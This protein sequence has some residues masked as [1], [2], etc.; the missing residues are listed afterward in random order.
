MG[1]N[2]DELGLHLE[3]RVGIRGIERPARQGNS[4]SQGT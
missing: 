4:V 2:K 3:G 1:G